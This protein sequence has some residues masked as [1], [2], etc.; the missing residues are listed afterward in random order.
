MNIAVENPRFAP[1]ERAVPVNN[2]RS[3][4]PDAVPSHNDQHPTHTS[5]PDDDSNDQVLRV[6][7]HIINRP[8]C[9]CFY[10]FQVFALNNSCGEKY[11]PEGSAAPVR[12]T[13]ESVRIAFQMTPYAL[14]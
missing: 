8:Y 3:S 2:I 10:I 9:Y 12:Q 4:T 11:F 7:I 1:S 14:R 5:K 13:S 6:I